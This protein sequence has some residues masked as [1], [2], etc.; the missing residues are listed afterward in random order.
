L[1]SV[2]ARYTIYKGNVYVKLSAIVKEGAV[3]FGKIFTVILSICG[4]IIGIN[5]VRVLWFI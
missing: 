4:V 3:D 2:I 5:Y 1:Y